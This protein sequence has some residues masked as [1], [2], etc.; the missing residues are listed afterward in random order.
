M[1]STTNPFT[2]KNIADYQYF[3]KEKIETAIQKSSDAFEKWSEISVSERLNFIKS[4]INTL[5][6]NKQLLAETAVAEMGKPLKQALAELHKCK[7]LCEFYLQNSDFF[8]TGRKINTDGCESY[9]KYEPLGVVLG[10]MPWNFPYWQVF[11]FVIPTIIAGNTVL[12]KHSSNVAGCSILLEKLFTEAGFPENVYQNLL[13]PG[14][15]VKKV[16]ENK[17]VKAISLTGSEKAG[18]SAASAAANQIK[19]A[20]LE[21]GGSNALIVLNDADLEKTIPEAVIARFQNTGQSCIAA[22]RF[23]VQR[24]VYDTFM[25]GFT[26]Q[27]AALKSG[28]PMNENTYIGPMARVDLAEEV[29]KQVNDSVAMGAKIVLGGKRNNAFYEPTILTNVTPDM[30]VFSQEVFGPAVPV[31]PFDTFE[32][33]VA[34]SNQSDFGLGVS[35]FTS[36][37]EAIKEKVHRFQEGAVFINALVKSDPALPFGGI[38]RSGYGRELSMEGIHEF[39]NVKTVYIK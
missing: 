37:I 11:R 21:L 26:A 17:T 39:V 16:I 14:S 24:G 36:D 31:I 18:A 2:L 1:L 30:P 33:A 13:I 3:S 7:L 28:D 32:E 25:E 20:V 4:L 22:K 9:T 12:L 6:K 8:L 27:V 34:L 38:K 35:I 29:E 10:I 19:K 23:L 15:D 5:T